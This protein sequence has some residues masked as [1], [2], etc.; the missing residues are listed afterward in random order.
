MC[1]GIEVPACTRSIRRRAI[2]FLMNMKAVYGVG[3]QA[4]HTGNQ[5]YF[6]ALLNQV[7]IAAD[8]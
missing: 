7:Y 5:Q 2:A 3:R 1:I 4:R 6:R 8:L